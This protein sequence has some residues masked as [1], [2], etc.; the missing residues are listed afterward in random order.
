MEKKKISLKKKV[1][2]KYKYTNLFKFNIPYPENKFVMYTRGRTG[3]TVLTDLINC[4]PDIYC[5]VEIFNFLYSNNKVK[6]PLL[7]INSCSKRAALYRK[8]VYGFK[9]KIGQLMN[10]HKYADYDKLLTK[11]HQEGWKYIYLKRVNFL[12][13]QLSNIVAANTNVYHLK[14]GEQKHKEK[15]L[16]KCEQL[17]RGIEY[18]E[19]SRKKRKK[20]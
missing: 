20:I 16:V 19:K 15:I 14:N 5:D 17:L 12:R 7:Y 13:H 3:S 18:G 10:E 11:L 2:S 8:K 6:Y 4:H 9:V 1:Q